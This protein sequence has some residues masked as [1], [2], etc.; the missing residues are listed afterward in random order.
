MAS[1]GVFNLGQEWDMS[2]VICSTALVGPQELGVLPEMPQDALL[3]QTCVQTAGHGETICAGARSVGGRRAGC[4][5]AGCAD[6]P[7][8]CGRRGQLSGAHVPP[9]ACNPTG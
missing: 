5:G 3:Q 9:Q 2:R 8:G 4:G 7:G 1:N 6:E